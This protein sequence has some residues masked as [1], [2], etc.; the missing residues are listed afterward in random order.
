MVMGMSPDEYWDGDP[1]LALAYRQ[2]WELKQEAEFNIR[3]E[4]AWINNMYTY[5]VMCKVAPLFSSF[6]DNKTKPGEYMEEPFDFSKEVDEEAE[7]ER[8]REK[9]RAVM[10]TW[11]INTNQRMKKQ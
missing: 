2:A 5:A 8:Q 3:N 1:D 10:E 7:M 9:A 6:A 4:Y 11:A